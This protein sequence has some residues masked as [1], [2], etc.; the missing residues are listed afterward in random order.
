MSDHI[1]RYEALIGRFVTWADTRPDVRAAFVVGSRART[2]SP[3]DQWSDLDVVM[4]ADSPLVLLDDETWLLSLGDPEITFREPT[5]VGIWEERRVLFANG[6][7]ADFS[8]LPAGLIDDLAGTSPGDDLHNQTAGVVSRGYRVLV[9]K[10]GRLAPALRMLATTASP[11]SGGPTQ[12]EMDGLLAAFWYHCVWIAKKLGRGELYT[13]HECLDGHQREITMRLLRWAVGQRDDAWHGT[14]FMERWVPAT[15]ADR[16]PESWA[17][18]DL[19]DILRAQD[20]MMD[21]VST[22]A[23]EVAG[24]RPSPAPP[25]GRSHG[26]SCRSRIVYDPAGATYGRGNE[27]G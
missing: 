2:T 5:A 23:D 19:A 18:H 9:D 15:V 4:F 26:Q 25:S 22:L 27:V 8:I 3:A 16:L 11:A 6:C 20:A 12:E 17:R 7:D 14:R 13:A 1:A 21:V 10:D 24:S